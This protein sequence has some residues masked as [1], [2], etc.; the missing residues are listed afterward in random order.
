M[1][2]LSC[3]H[4]DLSTKIVKDGQITVGCDASSTGRTFPVK[5]F[6]LFNINGCN[7]DEKKVIE[8]REKILDEQVPGQ[9]NLR[10]F[11]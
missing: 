8:I 6:G 5:S 11:I 4:V 2:C 10:D 1:S 3:R 9:M 7:Q